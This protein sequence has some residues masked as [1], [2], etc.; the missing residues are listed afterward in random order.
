MERKKGRKHIKQKGDTY[1]MTRRFK[2]FLVNG[3]KSYPDWDIDMQEEARERV[4]HEYVQRLYNG[5]ADQMLDDLRWEIETDLQQFI[6]DEHYEVCQ[7]LRDIQQ[8]L[9]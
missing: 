3:F 5:S 2:W 4:V 8:E 7:L 1:Y 9:G 6:Q